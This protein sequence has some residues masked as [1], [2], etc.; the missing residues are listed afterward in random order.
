MRR[1]VLVTTLLVAVLAL[2]DWC[3]PVREGLNATYYANTSW[4][5]PAVISTVDPQP[6]NASVL[7]AFHGPPPPE[8]STTWAGS[9]LAM[10]DG[11]YALATISDDESEVFV[12]GQR[13]VDNGGRRV[14]PRGATGLVNL[15]RGVHAIYV[16]YVQ[17]GGPFH[18]ELLWARAGA[19]LEAMPVWALTPRRASFWAFALS[20]GLKRSLAGAEWLW[21]GSLVLWVL[22]LIWSAI[23][24]GKRWLEGE[25]AWPAMKWVLAGSLMLNGA[26]VWWGL[27]GGS[28]APDEITPALV[29][30]GASRWFAHGWF[31]RY[32]PF[33]YYILTAAFSPLMLLEWLGRVDLGSAAPY[34]VMAFISRVISLAA[35]TGILVAIYAAG[36]Q[37]F[38]RR[39]GLFAAAMFALVVPFVYYAKT[40]NLDVPYLFWFAISLVFYVRALGSLSA[41]DIIG[42]AA[43]GAL[44]ICTKDQAYA[45]YPLM[46]FAILAR[47]WRVNRD[48][49]QRHPLW[50]ALFDRRML[51]AAVVAAGV[52]TGV[53]D[54][55][56][57]FRGFAEHVSLITGPATETYRDFAPTLEGRLALL[58]LTLNIVR[59]AWGWPMLL[60][61]AAGAAL[62]LMAPPS[63][64]MAA[65]L[66]LPVVSYYLAFIDVVLY[67]YDRF[68]LPVCLVLSL[69]GGLAFDRWLPSGARA[70]SWRGVGVA[71]V[72]LC[73]LLYALTVDIVMLRDSRY[74]TER[75]LGAHL[76]A[77]DLV[78]YVFPEQ[79]YPRLDHFNHAEITSV[80]QLSQDQPSY[81]VLNADYGRAEPRDSS[82]GQ[83]ITG[84]HD[85]SLG[86]SLVYRYREPVPWPW[87]P[88][89][90]RDLVGNR[91]ERPITSVLRHI[92]PWYEV[93]RKS[94]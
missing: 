47:I 27:P 73:T 17:A 58:R 13:V 57:N 26:A 38:G 2:V 37:A 29:L 34:A 1:I 10:N 65:W 56:F 83:L 39:A 28:W 31:D 49:G 11:G 90:P 44:A 88:G 35:G 12:D 82:I 63:R 66:A 20:A 36:A 46:P 78:G 51:W 69:F 93:F 41:R 92:N 80:T 7:D 6:S 25:T 85:G 67:N 60:A 75:W 5:N 4:S 74:A 23:L 53:H 15:T 72:F 21:V 30:G 91:T 43:C 71:A 79:Y 61:S 64:R 40:A 59:M 52:F 81:Y 77:G 62:A 9:F 33:H 32:P 70:R 42:F 24:K 54:L 76:E 22:T 8:F 3:N 18:I 45:L 55:V 84:L 16:R 94:R 50:R 87:L 68:M 89:V 86:Y 19:P 14:W 48:T